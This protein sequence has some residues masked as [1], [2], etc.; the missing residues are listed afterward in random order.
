MKQACDLDP[1]DLYIYANLAYCFNI[2]GGEN[3]KD[4]IKCCEDGQEC[5]DHGDDDGAKLMFLRNWVYALVNEKYYY[6][7][8]K[9]I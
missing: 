6:D 4:A 1:D 9:V 5:Y 7:A 2:L 8:V 3:Y